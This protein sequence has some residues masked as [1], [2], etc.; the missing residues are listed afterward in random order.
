[1]CDPSWKHPLDTSFA[2]RFGARWNPPGAFGALYLNATVAVAAANARRN[3]EGEIAT[4]YDLR[5]QQ[6]PVLVEVAVTESEFV[7]VVTA[8]GLR[9]LRLPASYPIGVPHRRCQ[10]IAVRAYDTSNIAGIACRSNADATANSY[11]GEELAIFDRSV[12]LARERRRMTFHRWYPT[13]SSK[14]RSGVAVF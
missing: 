7:D 14:G 12:H 2:K 11:L 4:L 10:N 9:A 13:E 8:T 5:P 6:Q 3:F 1:M